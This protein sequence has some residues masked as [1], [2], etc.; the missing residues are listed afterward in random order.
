MKVFSC[1]QSSPEWMALRL[2]IPTSSRMS[3]VV[4]PT[5]KASKSSEKLLMEL[6]AERITGMPEDD[7]RSSWMA[8]GATLEKDAAAFY[9]LQR[10]I[11]TVPVGF[12]T[13]DLGRWGASPDRL[14]GTDGLMEIKCPKGKN[15]LAWLLESGSA[16]E[17][18]FVQIQSQL[19]IAERSWCDVVSFHPLMPM[20]LSRINRDDKFIAM[21]AP[22]VAEFSDKLESKARE[23]AE[24]GWLAKD[25]VKVDPFSKETHEAYEAWSAKN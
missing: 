20:A 12:I 25:R 15:H 2:G 21:M 18:Y 17:E 6:L 8:R 1:L 7:F 13:D 19:W 11:D 23:L 14:V 22:L 16:Y 24:R 5:G 9:S 3:E 10:E 4:T